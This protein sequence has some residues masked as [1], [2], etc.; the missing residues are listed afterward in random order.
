MIRRLLARL[1]PTRCDHS[2]EGVA[3]YHDAALGIFLS[4]K[5]CRVCGQTLLI[6][7]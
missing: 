1:R 5:Q 4:L 6:E 7:V 2:W 3:M